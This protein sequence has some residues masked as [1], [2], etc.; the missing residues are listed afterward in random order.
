MLADQGSDV[1]VMPSNLFE[2]LPKADSATKAEKLAKGAHVRSSAGGSS[3][4][5]L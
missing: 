1:N 3:A 4:D 2:A 5:S